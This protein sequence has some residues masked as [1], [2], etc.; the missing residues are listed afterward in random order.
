MAKVETHEQGPD[1]HP[2]SGA[3]T[4]GLACRQWTTRSTSSS[5]RTAR[6]PCG[7]RSVTFR[8]LKGY[9]HQPGMKPVSEVDL[10]MG[11]SPDGG[12][13][14][15]TRQSRKRFMI[16]LD[17]NV[18]PAICFK[19]TRCKARRPAGRFIDR[20]TATRRVISVVVLCEA[21][22]V[23]LE[24]AYGYHK[25]QLLGCTRRSPPDPAGFEIEQR[26]LVHTS[27]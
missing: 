7:P 9:L 24:S 14:R 27:A 18:L 22:G 10:K 15:H 20:P 3:Q 23:V 16:G 17:T 12:L 13:K 26:D 8:S 1:D 6:L 19:T 2:T 4:P 25:A 5:R 11:R 21:G